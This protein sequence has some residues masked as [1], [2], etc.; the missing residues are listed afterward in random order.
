MQTVTVAGH[1]L[2]IDHDG[3][4]IS[5]SVREVRLPAEIG[6]WKSF[7]GR[8]FVTLMIGSDGSPDPTF[9]LNDPTCDLVAITPDCE[10]D[11][12]VETTPSVLETDKRHRFLHFFRGRLL[13]RVDIHGHFFEIDDETGAVT[14][15]WDSSKFILGENFHD[16]GSAVTDFCSFEGKIVVNTDDGPIYGFDSDGDLL[17]EYNDGHR[18][19]MG[20]EGGRFYLFFDG[21]GRIPTSKMKFEFDTER[22]EI[23]RSVN[24]PDMIVEKVLGDEE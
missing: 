1:E 21:G 15:H 20:S 19:A 14:N 7:D 13:T 9:D 22:G 4:R 11:W 16:V 2:T 12:V 18:W 24:A 5:G 8:L 6:T 17:W 10:L 23:V 3:A